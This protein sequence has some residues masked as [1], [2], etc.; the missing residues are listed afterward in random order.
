MQSVLLN[1][2]SALV[3]LEDLVLG[4]E[5]HHGVQIVIALKALETDYSL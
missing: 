3:H 4:G 2:T 1:S 5:D